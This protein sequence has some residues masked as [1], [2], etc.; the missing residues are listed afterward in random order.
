[1]P[2]QLR[3]P[4]TRSWLGEGFSLPDFVRQGEGKGEGGSRTPDTGHEGQGQGADGK[5][6]FPKLTISGSRLG[7]PRTPRGRK[8]ENTPDSGNLP[9]SSGC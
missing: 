8:G 4:P 1:M 3:L 7:G 5:D 6:M 9:R 2:E